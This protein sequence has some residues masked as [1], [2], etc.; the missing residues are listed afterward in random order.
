[1][2]VFTA[3]RLEEAAGGLDEREAIAG[4]GYALFLGRRS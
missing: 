4:D 3:E 1:M 2:N